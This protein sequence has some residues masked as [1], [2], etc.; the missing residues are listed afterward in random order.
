MHEMLN[1]LPYE[2]NS[3]SLDNQAFDRRPQNLTQ[4][5][6]LAGNAWLPEYDQQQTT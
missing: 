1:K 2:L 3:M 6:V 4:H 5:C